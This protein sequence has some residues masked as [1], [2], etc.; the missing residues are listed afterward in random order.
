MC[1]DP[2]VSEEAVKDELSQ[3]FC[4]DCSRKKGVKSKTPESAKSVSWQ[5]KSADEVH[6]P[7]FLGI[8]E[9]SDSG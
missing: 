1:H 4:A 6:I 9:H 2:V 5:G 3:W 8:L 7:I